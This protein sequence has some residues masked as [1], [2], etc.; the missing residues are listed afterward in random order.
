LRKGFTPY[1]KA[2]KYDFEVMDLLASV[3]DAVA[4]SAYHPP[5]IVRRGIVVGKVAVTVVE[6]M[7]K[8]G[9]SG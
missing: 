6:S 7:S 5:A 8:Y 3:C 1:R 4:T 9:R 2:Q